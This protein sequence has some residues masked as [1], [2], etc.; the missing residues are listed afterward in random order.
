MDGWITGGGNGWLWNGRKGRMVRE[1]W[2][3]EWMVV[4]W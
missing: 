4:L 3:K 2:R 1:K